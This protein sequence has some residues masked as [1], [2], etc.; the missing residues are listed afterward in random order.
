[1]A[2]CCFLIP[3]IEAFFTFWIIMAG[4]RFVHNLHPKKDINKNRRNK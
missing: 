2:K 1:M 4:D 3:V